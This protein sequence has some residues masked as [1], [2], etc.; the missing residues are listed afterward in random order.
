MAKKRVLLIEDNDAICEVVGWVLQEEGYE[1]SVC[2]HLAA[3]EI[4]ALKA[5]LIVLDE[6][7][8]EAEGH[9]LC[10]EI[11]A[12]KELKH[13]PVVIF[14]TAVDIE[15]IVKTCGADGFVRKPFD[16]GALVSEVDRLL[17][18]N[19]SNVLS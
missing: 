15:R 3:T 8:N 4:V 2:G 10:K 11:K 18:T 1:V 16:I 17:L 9:M 6:W 12:V 19:T 14:S 5:D 7:I 13:V